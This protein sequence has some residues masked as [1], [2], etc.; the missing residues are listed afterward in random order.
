MPKATALWLRENT[1]LTEQQISDFCGI[2]TMEINALAQ[3][4]T[5]V[6][7]SPLESL[8]LTSD[9][10]RR[11]EEDPSQSLELCTQIDQEMDLRKK[12][13]I[14]RTLT[15]E[16]AQGMA[17]VMTHHPNITDADIVSL[18]KVAKKDAQ[19]MRSKIQS[20]ASDL[21]MQDPVVLEICQKKA[22]DRRIAKVQTSSS[23]L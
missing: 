8:Q 16:K 12:K 20:G 21:Q 1:R 22:L 6:P 14:D 4:G 7:F 18:L 11:C 10:I 15:P 5:L 19:N 9:E 13:R 3:K 17:W 23:A 2:H